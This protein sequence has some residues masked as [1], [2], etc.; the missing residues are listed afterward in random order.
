VSVNKALSCLLQGEPASK[1]SSS[2]VFAS[3]PPPK[4][5]L[6]TKKSKPIPKVRSPTFASGIRLYKER[7]ERVRR[8]PLS[9]M[10]AARTSCTPPQHLVQLSVATSLSVG[11]VFRPKVGV[12]NALPFQKDGLKRA[13]LCRQTHHSSNQFARL[14]ERLKDA[15]STPQTDPA[16]CRPFGHMGSSF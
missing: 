3:S 10:T 7:E 11:W 14:P 9:Y 1:A 4:A 6:K 13:C 5:G 12:N 8:P 2:A 16:Q 15:S